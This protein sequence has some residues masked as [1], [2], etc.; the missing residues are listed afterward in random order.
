MEETA[1]NPLFL[2]FVL[3][4][5]LS[6]FVDL[7]I[8]FYVKFAKMA[9]IILV[10]FKYQLLQ[11]NKDKI[12]LKEKCSLPVLMDFWIDPYQC[13]YS[14]SGPSL[15]LLQ[16][17]TVTYKMGTDSQIVFCTILMVQSRCII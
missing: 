8:L 9:I 6:I 2:A 5:V 10:F 3:S 15:S 14:L 4:T 16:A 11:R 1:I 7:I 12:L 17:K 13:L